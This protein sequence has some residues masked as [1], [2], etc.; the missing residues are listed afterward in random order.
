MRKLLCCLG[1]WALVSLLQVSCSSK[2]DNGPTRPDTP[3]DTIAP[4]VVAIWPDTTNVNAPANPTIRI[5]FSEELDSAT[6]TSAAIVIG[7]SVTGVFA[8]SN[9]QVTFTPSSPLQNGV[10]Y[11]IEINSGISD[12]SGNH[13]PATVNSSF[14]VEPY[15]TSPGTWVHLVS[16]M[17]YLSGGGTSPLS[18]IRKR[19]GT[20]AVCGYLG[21]GAYGGTLASVDSSGTLL[22]L[23]VFP[24]E[25]YTTMA[26]VDITERG[27]GTLAMCGYVGT[28]SG[29]HGYL[30]AATGFGT[31]VTSRDYTGRG[32]ASLGCITNS[33]TDGYLLSGSSYGQ[34]FES[35][36]YFTKTDYFGTPTWER[37]LGTVSALT[38]FE[39]RAHAPAVN[40]G[41]LL[42]GGASGA[43]LNNMYVIRTDDSGK[44]IW[45]R[46]FGAG[47]LF[48]VAANAANN[49][50]LVGESGTDLIVLSIDD[51]GT[52]LWRTNTG[53]GFGRAILPLND[54]GCVVAGGLNLP[55]DPYRKV[56]LARLDASGVMVWRRELCK[57]IGEAVIEAYNGG[58]IIAGQ[59][60]LIKTDANGNL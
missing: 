15:T 7:P 56:I 26:F 33:T 45:E 4:T 18:V 20:Y 53:E 46:S 6:V 32:G 36:F 12:R 27:D 28:G 3:R 44:V 60:Y 30:C 13:L 57:G 2:K 51:N 24:P 25:Q 55:A 17:K 35:R 54:G 10:L 58:Y 14:V 8:Y 9:K 34:G 47:G 29:F 16:T 50:V 5:T 49:Y 23:K 40:G 21:G 38:S 11:G 52:E 1:L 22:W 43:F 39:A 42:C 19:D 37:Y 31:P 59:D 48:G 41:Y